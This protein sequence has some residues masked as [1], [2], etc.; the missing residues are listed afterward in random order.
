[1]VEAL[2]MGHASGERGVPAGGD[3][4]LALLRHSIRVDYNVE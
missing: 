2:K 3:W 1:M 4:K